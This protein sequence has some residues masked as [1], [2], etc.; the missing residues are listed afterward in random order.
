[1]KIEILE[2]EKP[3][4]HKAGHFVMIPKTL[5]KAQVFPA[6]LFLVN[7]ETHERMELF[8]NLE[9]P[10]SP[11]TVELDLQQMCLRV[12]GEAKQGYFRFIIKAQEE[13]L[14]IYFEKTPILG[15]S[16]LNEKGEL[17]KTFFKGDFLEVSKKLSPFKILFKSQLFLGCN[18]EQD[19]DLMR[20][21]KDLREILPLWYTLG[22]LTP[23][24]K[25]EKGPVLDLLSKAEK[26]I[27]N[28]ESQK[29][30]D[31]LFNLY[32][33]GFSEGLVPRA[34]DLEYQGIVPL[35]KSSETAYRLLSQGAELIGW[36]FFQERGSVFHILPCLPSQFVCGKITG[37]LSKNG[38]VVHLEWTKHRLRRICIVVKEDFLVELKLPSDVESYRLTVS[39]KGRGRMI[40]KGE[41]FKA[42]AGECLWL[43]LFQK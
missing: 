4:S 8:W 34:F 19:F 7:E 10:V 32:L 43:D 36:L 39:G 15:L 37:L 23:C 9:G 27:E 14:S 1:M 26:A 16:F 21:R 13:N 20:R 41:S 35:S 30:Y 17:Q 3:F 22:R 12:F 29:I 42:K 31:L 6:A 18:K 38:S 25:E 5:W 11:F 33:T 40:E 24:I 2:K 28:R